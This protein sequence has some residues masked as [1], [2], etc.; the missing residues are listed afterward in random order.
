MEE[1]I[2]FIIKPLL[3]EPDKLAVTINGPMAAVKIA[4]TDMGKVIGKSGTVIS[5]IRTLI[6]SYNMATRTPFVNIVLEEV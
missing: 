2:T 5:A 3:S 4:K 1:I 6:R